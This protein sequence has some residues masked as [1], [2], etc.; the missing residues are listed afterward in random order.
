MSSDGV[1]LEVGHALARGDQVRVGSDAGV[2]QCAGLAP[3]KTAEAP[4][5]SK[6]RTRTG[7]RLKAAAHTTAGNIATP[8]HGDPLDADGRQG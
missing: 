8:P 7:R 3:P 4:T 1:F 2:Q 6:T 5:N